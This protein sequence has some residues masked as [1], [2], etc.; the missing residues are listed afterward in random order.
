MRT[1]G[2]PVRSRVCWVRFCTLTLIFEVHGNTNWRPVCES[3][4]GLITCAMALRKYLCCILSSSELPNAHSDHQQETDHS[5]HSS[6][7]LGSE[8]EGIE[9]SCANDEHLSL[10]V[11]V[12]VFF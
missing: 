10:S 5:A 11:L 6:S 1:R 2:L 9:M 12:S 3:D 7:N 8:S 4:L